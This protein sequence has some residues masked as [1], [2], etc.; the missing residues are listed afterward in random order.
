V[1]SPVRTASFLAAG[2]VLCVLLVWSFT[3]LPSFGHFDGAYGSLLTRTAV[4]QRHATNVV[5]AVVFD[6]RG[7]DTLGE[8]F[9]LFT[10]AIGGALLL[11]SGRGG[12]RGVGPVPP[13][14]SLRVFAAALAGFI[15]LL[16]VYVAA[17][18]YLTP[19]GGFQGGVVLATAPVLA[20]LGSDYR[21]YRSVIPSALVDSAEGSALA[22]FVALGLVGVVAGT[23]F[24]ENVLPLGETGTMASAG[25]IALLNGFAAVAVAAALTLFFGEFLE[26]LATGR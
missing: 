14:D 17:H 9:I 20:Y 1:S 26:E 11:R 22:S 2:S 15:V 19:G 18:G 10:A 12:G 7:F 16:G 24:L 5:S 13:S 3:G 4:E 21:T 8:E 25:T 23:A 6:Y